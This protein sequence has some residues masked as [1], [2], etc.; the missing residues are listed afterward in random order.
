MIVRNQ[1]INISHTVN[2][3]A[4]AEQII[5]THSDGITNCIFCNS[6][7]KILDISDNDNLSN[8]VFINNITTLSSKTKLFYE[9]I[10]NDE[11]H[12]FAEKFEQFFTT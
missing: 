8:E 5:T 1:D 7:C 10:K 12:L 2:L 3:I 9:K 11:L 4:G 6:D